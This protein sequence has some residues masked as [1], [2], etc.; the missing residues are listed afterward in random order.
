MDGD[1]YP[2]LLFSAQRDDTRND[3]ELLSVS[4]HFSR[5]CEIEGVGGV[6]ATGIFSVV[7]LNENDPDTTRMLLRL[8]EEV[9]RQRD[10]RYTNKDIAARI[11]QLSEL[12]K[13][14]VESIGDVVGLWGELYIMS[15]SN[16][17]ELA[18]QRWCQSKNA[19]YDFVTDYFAL[20]AKTT[21]LSRRKHRFSLEQLRPNGD[22][23]VYV[24]SLL[25]VEISSGRTAAEL[26]EALYGQLSDPD[27]RA[28]FIN[29]CIVKGGSHLYR[30]E[31]KLG[32]FPDKSSLK[33]FDASALPVPDVAGDAPIKNVRFDVDLSNLEPIS[34][35]ETV[36][37]QSFGA[38]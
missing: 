36:T 30:N 38:A 37:V 18:V 1:A 22:F 25:V 3:I 4:A 12:F 2:S 23:Q 24:A 14:I 8:L 6:R 34:Q 5:D 10:A 19:K 16:N 26:M 32:V 28:N 11:Q 13:L 35:N 21:M 7:R 27:L 17:L 20:E 33:I 9:F 29:Q 15:Q 31:I